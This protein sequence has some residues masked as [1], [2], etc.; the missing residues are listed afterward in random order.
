MIVLTIISFDSAPTQGLSARFDE[1]GGTIGRADHNQL[2]LPDPQRVISREH[3]RIVFRNGV[4]CLVD[5]GSNPIL[6]N[7]RAGGAG[8][9]H[10]LK[11]GDKIQIG[12]YVI[13]VNDATHAENE[14]PFADLF[15]D[16]LAGTKLPN[17]LSSAPL[18]VESRS[19]P[20]QVDSPLF[21]IP[22]D[23]DPF[24]P[25][26]LP[27]PGDAPAGPV[28]AG[29][30]PAFE[31]ADKFPDSRSML[32]G[33]SVDDLFDLGSLPQSNDPFGMF[34]S[35]AGSPQRSVDSA[36]PLAAFGLSDSV[37][38]ATQGDLGSELNT[39]MPLVNRHKQS[40]SQQPSKAAL[41]SRASPPGAVFS[42]DSAIVGVGQ[43]DRSEARIS[44][45]Q[46]L[47]R[48]AGV[49]DRSAGAEHPKAMTSPQLDS[50]GFAAEQREADGNPLLQAL[51]EGLGVPG[52]H[53]GTL[54]PEKMRLIGELLHQSTRGAVELLIAR[55]ALK[56]E[57]HAEPTMIVA[58][59]NNPLK[60][61]PTVDVALQH[62]LGP[63]M[64]GFMPPAEAM[65]D[66]FDD[67]RAH[68]LGVMAGMRAALEGVLGRFDPAR[69]EANLA[70]RSSI[71]DLIPGARKARL[72]E[73]FQA[74]FSQ[75]QTE[76]HEDF[77]ELFGQAFLH[78]YK[79]QLARLRDESP[80]W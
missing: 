4:Y 58:T 78:A 48:P 36:D 69:L 53:L 57:M 5:T 46:Q 54:T 8:S 7:G 45:P 71:G 62:L 39:P 10:P 2:V 26:D 70:H 68:Q 77:D 32:P 29:H 55:A 40:E 23:W 42:W 73:L 74:L 41:S 60:F 37:A 13:E 25:D 51:L 35:S 19:S 65:R 34:P 44:S 18:Q 67:L 49:D 27:F 21:G 22:E 33:Q 1:L 59:K 43:A 79:A 80:K 28:P 6:V 61:S 15:A 24:A 14:D 52:L 47:S 72:W 75:L 64:P 66:A 3:A 16:G 20:A 38:P 30:L 9:E 63:S 12:A 11:P 17:N 31:I 76:A 56:R 50:R